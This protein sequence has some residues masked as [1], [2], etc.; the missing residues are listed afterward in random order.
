LLIAQ[1]H[2]RVCAVTPGD[3]K[4]SN[5]AACAHVRQL[6]L[7]PS[8]LEDCLENVTTI[9]SA[10]GVPDRGIALRATME[11]R[12]NRVKEMTQHKERPRVALLEWCDP[13]MGC[14]YWIPELIH[15]AGGESIHSPPP[16][17]ATPTISF[18]TL[19]A[20]KPDVV[21]FALCGFG[22]TRAASEIVSSWGEKNINDLKQ[23][24][25]GRMF[26]I[27]GNYLVNRSGP[28]VVESCE[29]IAEAI[30]PELK[31]HFG[32]YATDLLTSLDVAAIFAE[33]GIR[34]GSE[35]I[36]PDPP[37]ELVSRP[38]SDP[39]SRP[40]KHSAEVVALQLKYIEQ[41]SIE[42][43]FLLNSKANQGRWCGAERFGAV[44]R[45]HSDFCRLFN[46]TVEVGASEENESIATV[47]V[48]LP[49]SGSSSEKVQ[50]LWTMIAEVP[51]G[52]NRLEWR[53]EKVGMA[54]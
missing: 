12:L 17:G 38:N 15:A 34:T 19:L 31:G 42:S 46:E 2:C 48:S 8:N 53:T 43:A 25:G 33:K 13:I 51:F 20:S 49:P 11:G 14:G 22:L 9:A 23:I 47:R 24:C 52:Q 18:Q 41:G 35:K 4:D 1:D 3:V 37:Q 28:R 7:K 10:M 27:D 26:V 5:V 32:H 39:V 54:N 6:V 29:A 16:G 40:L 45:S 50:L 36:R 21:V 30:H 44:L